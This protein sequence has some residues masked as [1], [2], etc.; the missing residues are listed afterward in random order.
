MN[1]PIGSAFV[2]NRTEAQIMVMLFSVFFFA[3]AFS[4]GIMTRRLAV[5]G[6]R[7]G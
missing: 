5:M 2:A 3:L 1:M 4:A 6:L 7:H